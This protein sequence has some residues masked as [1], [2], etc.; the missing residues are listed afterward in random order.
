MLHK[1]GYFRVLEGGLLSFYCPGCK[2][3]HWI[4]ESWQ[5]SFE[6]GK[7]T[8]SPSILVKHGRYKDLNDPINSYEKIICHSFIRGGK[9]EFLSDC[10]HELAG[11]T[12]EM[13]KEDDAPVHA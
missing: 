8:V 3:S 1:S 4:N 13:E 12:V 5:L 7:P 9:I 10:T 6:S 11:K 2:C